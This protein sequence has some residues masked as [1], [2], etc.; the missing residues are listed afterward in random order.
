MGD[1]APEGRDEFV[2]Y[3]AAAIEVPGSPAISRIETVSK[4]TGVFLVV[5]VIERDLGT[6]YCTA[7]FV[8]PKQ[9]YVTKHRKLIPTGMERIIW[10]QGDSSTL[11]VPEI[12]FPDKDNKGAGMSAK[13]SATICW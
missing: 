11:P 5:G 7:V 10:G 13:L 4:E 6:L 8:D 1:R 2:R 3:H 9:G 12:H